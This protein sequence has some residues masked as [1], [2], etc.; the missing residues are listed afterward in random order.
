MYNQA[1]K[2]RLI[3]FGAGYETRYKRNRVKLK[4]L[5]SKNQA[6]FPSKLSFRTLVKSIGEDS[7]IAQDPVFRQAVPGGRKTRT[8]QFV[9]RA[10]RVFLRARGDIHD[11]QA[12]LEN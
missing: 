4:I 2:W 11:T 7:W 9:G 6:L 8:I 5:P 10:A 12:T 1:Q 3:S